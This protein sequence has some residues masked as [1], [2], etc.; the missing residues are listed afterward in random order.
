MAVPNIFKFFLL[1]VLASTVLSCAQSEAQRDFEDQALV[2]PSGITEM[3][4]NGTPVDD[5]ENDPDD[6]RIAPAFRGTIDITTSA[7]P[8]PVSFNGSFEILINVQGFQST[9][10]LQVY[11]FQQPNELI[12]PI[13]QQAGQLQPGFLTVRLSPQQFAFSSG[14]FGNLY[15]IIIYDGQLNI[16]T[17]GDVQVTN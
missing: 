7:Y 5:G 9:S 6:W 3:T 15:R 1:S 12:G 13:F 4:I 16:I 11:A 14:N 17:Y 2:A 10:G 8:N